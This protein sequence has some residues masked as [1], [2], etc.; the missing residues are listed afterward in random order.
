MI[1]TIPATARFC[2]SFFSLQ[3]LRGMKEAVPLDAYL[4]NPVSVSAYAIPPLRAV[5]SRHRISQ[6]VHYWWTLRINRLKNSYTAFCRGCRRHAVT[7]FRYFQPTVFA[8]LST[9]GAFAH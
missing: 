5:A 6:A 3:S 4:E 2:H 8:F 7:P 9:V 1:A